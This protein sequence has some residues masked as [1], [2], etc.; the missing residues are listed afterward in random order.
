MFAYPGKR[1]SRNII[2]AFILFLFDVVVMHLFKI[3]FGSLLQML[4][5][6]KVVA[7][8]TAEAKEVESSLSLQTTVSQ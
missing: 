1:A 4:G 6:S 8:R 5:M 2:R 3:P 7:E